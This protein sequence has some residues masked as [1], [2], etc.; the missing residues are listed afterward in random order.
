MSSIRLL[1]LAPNPIESA[2][3]RYRIAQY[4]PTL[5]Q[6]GI[7]GDLVPFLSPDLFAEIYRR[8][9]TLRKVLGL[10]E[11]IRRRLHLTLRAGDYDAVLVSREAMTLGPPI[12]EWLLA[13][14]G[15]RPLIFDYDDATWVPYDSPTYGRLTRWI[16][17]PG[18][19]ARIIGMS[20]AVIA[21]NRYLADYAARFN[22]EVTIIPTVVDAGAYRRP[23][24]SAV[25]SRQSPP[26]LPVIGWI[27]SHST[28]QYLRLITQALSRVATRHR[29]IFRVIGAGEGWTAP[30]GVASESR[31]W[32]L[33]REITDFQELDIGVYPIVDD[34]WSRGKCAFKAIQYQ[35]AGVACVSSPIGMVR[36]VIESGQDGLLAATEDEWVA[37]LER[38]LT[39]SAYRWRLAE[40]GRLNVVRRYS[41]AVQA[42]RLVEVI[43]RA[44]R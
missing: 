20:R 13:A 41:L 16:K 30:A 15:R 12:I 32:R 11:S 37:A 21:G 42:P 2:T 7:T 24:H 4:L 29:F 8:G 26:T 39:D 31:P 10:A 33:D 28:S 44:V 6:A 14:V 3:T 25:T 5:A 43:R 18:K 17:P 27:G 38:L 19:T 40:A 9:Q 36:E 35:A 23:A 34:E 1:I 22:P